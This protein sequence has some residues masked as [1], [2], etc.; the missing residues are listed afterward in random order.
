[1]RNRCRYLVSVRTLQANHGQKIVTSDTGK[2]R[3][4]PRFGH[5]AVLGTL[6]AISAACASTSAAGQPAPGVD[7]DQ[8][9]P[10][11][12]EQ[13]SSADSPIETRSEIILPTSPGIDISIDRVSD[14]DS[15]RAFSNE[16]DLEIRLIGV[17]APE[18]TECFG[19]QSTEIL[20][21]MLDADSVQLHP[22]PPEID[23]FGRELGFIVADG[24]F[25]NLSLIEQ[26]AVVAR[27]QSDHDF[28]RDFEDAEAQAFE[29]ERGLWAGDACGEPSNA[30]LEI[31]D[32][33]ADA[34]GNDQ[35][36]P[37]GEWVEIQNQGD[38][39]TSLDGW[40]LRDEST[41]HRYEF[42]NV[43]LA[44]G[45]RVRIFTGCG[46]DSLDQDPGELFWCSQEP[47]VWNNGGDT[48]FLLDPNGTFAA[49]RSVGG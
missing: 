14:G 23:D 10:A 22:W 4:S 46:A 19:D 26:G 8:A 13:A 27:A 49:T 40:S 15:I 42:P 3:I 47:P 21:E 29:A 45:Q 1:M 25:V 44:A 17:N 11:R 34:P 35:E 16:G 39:T 5:R 48:A 32:A 12:S 31:I 7:T 37:N 33:E 28:V 41:R 6:V 36:N 20:R 9:D 18:A 24:Q 30:T 2:P 43:S 38:D